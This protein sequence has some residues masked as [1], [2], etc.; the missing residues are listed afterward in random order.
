V[1]AAG[2]SSPHWRGWLKPE[3]RYLVPASSFAE[4][5]PEPNK[6]GKLPRIECHA[7]II[8]ASRATSIDLDHARKVRRG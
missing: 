1:R 2:T 3:N 5:A 8:G 4:Y 7:G 6:D